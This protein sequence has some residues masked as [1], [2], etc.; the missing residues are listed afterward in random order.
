[1]DVVVGISKRKIASRS[2]KELEPMSRSQKKVD[3]SST[4]YLSKDW[5]H[6]IVM[7]YLTHAENIQN[8]PI[9]SQDVV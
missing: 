2:Y 5:S 4:N 3:I 9:I 7:V 1:M 6:P 8:I